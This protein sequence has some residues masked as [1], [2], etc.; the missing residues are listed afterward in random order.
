MTVKSLIKHFDPVFSGD[1]TIFSESS[2]DVLWDGN[3][4]LDIPKRF[5]KRKICKTF[6]DDNDY[7]IQIRDYI[8]E[9][10]VASHHLIIVLKD[11]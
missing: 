7:G 4:L 3:F 8:N 11:K 1:I 5:Y 6:N 9:Y 10:N 2:D